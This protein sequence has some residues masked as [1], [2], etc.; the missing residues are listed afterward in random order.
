MSSSPQAL[1]ASFRD[2]AGCLF[3]YGDRI[4]RMV[5]PAGVPDLALF[6]DSRTAQKHLAA[7]SVAGTRLLEDPELRDLL[8]DPSLPESCRPLDGGIILEHER[9][10]FPSFPYEWPPE[11]LHAAG[12]LTLELATSLLNDGLGLKDATPYN[13]L[14]RGPQPVFIDVLSFERRDPGDSTWLPYAQFVRTFLLP[15]LANRYFGIAIDQI[16]TTRRDGLEPE[17]VYRW[18]KPLQKIRPPFLS[19]V[20]MPKW[21][22]A[23]HKQDDNSIYQ[24]RPSQDPERARF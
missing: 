18:L 8:A 12:A 13:V 19:L 2:P 21:L 7:G 10:S 14:F 5:S 20:S 24:K 6:L 17:E 11:M 9:I 23:R 22:G 4:L 3:A 16:L 1:A 15:L